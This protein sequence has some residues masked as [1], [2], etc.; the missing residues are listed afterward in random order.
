M[1]KAV[2]VT[3]DAWNVLWIKGQAAATPGGTVSAVID[4]ILSDARLAGRTSAPHRSVIGS[5]DLPDDDPDLARADAYIGSLFTA[6]LRRPMLVKESRATSRGR[7]HRR[8]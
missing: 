3:L 4:R 6:S 8:D 1:K 5:I 7:G 2:S